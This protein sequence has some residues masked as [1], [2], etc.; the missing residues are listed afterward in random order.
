[1]QAV[2]A[3]DDWAMLEPEVM[4]IDGRLDNGTAPDVE[5]DARLCIQSGARNMVFDCRRLTY[6]SGA[7]L[8]VLLSLAREMKMAGGKF[9][10]CG[11]QP[12]VKEMFE[13]AGLNAV[14]PAYSN[15]GEATVAR[16]A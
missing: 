1:M 13:A 4:E 14:I 7:G 11:L 2:R 9:A 10:V 6:M 16:A 3:N 15:P 8:R 5:E 12:Q